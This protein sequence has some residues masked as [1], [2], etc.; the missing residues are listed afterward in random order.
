MDVLEG[1]FGGR[2][3]EAHTYQYCAIITLSILLDVCNRLYTVSL[4]RL[5]RDLGTSS[6]VKQAFS[7]RL[8]TNPHC[9]C[10]HETGIACVRNIIYFLTQENE[11][12]PEA[13]YDCPDGFY[14]ASTAQ[15]RMWHAY[16]LF[17]S[18]MEDGI[19]IA[20]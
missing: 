3:I 17:F 5:A 16:Q 13:R 15:V 12:D 14:H 20:G 19:C 6:Y 1:R 18:G 2:I 11:W 10:D 7:F 4:V 8:D 9:C